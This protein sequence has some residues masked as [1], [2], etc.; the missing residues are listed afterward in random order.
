MR[1]PKLLH[2]TSDTGRY[3]GKDAVVFT[4]LRRL[5]GEGEFDVEVVCC[6]WLMRVLWKQGC[7]DRPR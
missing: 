2:V 3:G 4:L 7:P 6:A 5:G 1:R